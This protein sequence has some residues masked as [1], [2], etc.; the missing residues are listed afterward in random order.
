MIQHPPPPE[1]S[2]A[3]CTLLLRSVFA[4]PEVSVGELMGTAS[5]EGTWSWRE[6]QRLSPWLLGQLFIW[7][8]RLFNITFKCL[9][10]PC[11]LLPVFVALGKEGMLGR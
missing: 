8:P 11:S 10:S 3:Y 6:P 9:H 5:S 1:H 4:E 7:G 2:A